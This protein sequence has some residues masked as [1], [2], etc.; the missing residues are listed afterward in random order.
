[1]VSVML[2]KMGQTVSRLNA[3]SA[4]DTNPSSVFVDIREEV[5]GRLERMRSSVREFQP[6]LE[7]ARL[8]KTRL[9]EVAG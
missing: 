4:W 2:L 9:K 7:S 3:S 1:M 5:H 6:G 8:L